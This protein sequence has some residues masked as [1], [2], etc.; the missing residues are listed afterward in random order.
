MRR[1][2]RS[3]ATVLVALALVAVGCGE[4][5][6]TAAPE[7]G[8]HGP[9]GQVALSR[10]ADT[11]DVDQSVQL[12]AIMPS[13]PGSVAPSVSWSSSDPN[14]AIV[15]QNGVLFA[16][17]SGR[18][19]VTAT[20]HGQS[21]ATTVTVRPSVREV[22]FDSDSLAIS[23]SQSVKLPYRVLDSDGNQ[24]DL[25]THTVEW[26]TSNAQVVPLTGDA[27]ITGRAIGAADLLLRVD[28]KEA[29]TRVKVLAKPVASVV[30]SPTSL[31]IGVTQNA[32]LTVSTYDVQENLLTGRSLTFSSSDQTIAY[33][34]SSGV[35]TGVANGQATITVTADGRKSTTVPVT[36]GAGPTNP[37]VSV[38]S[39]AV[40]LNAT[41]LTAGQTTQANAVT[42][43]GSG[44]VLTGRTIVWTTSDPTVASVDGAG[45]ISALKAGSVTVTATSEGKT[46]TGT[47][48]VTAPANAPTPVASMTLAVAPSIT[49]GQSAQATVVLKDAAGNVLSGRTVTWVSS[50]GSV[51]SVSSSGAVAALKAGGVTI[52]A[53]TDGV[54]AS[55]VVTAVAPNTA[56][57]MITLLAGATQ[58]NIGQ[59]TQITAVVRDANGAVLSGVPVTFTSSPS[60][61]VTISGSGV[62]AGVSVGSAQIYAKADTVVRSIGITVIDTTTTPPPPT[63]PLPPAG[64]GTLNAIATMA[65]LPQATVNATYPTPVRQIRVAAGANLQAALDAAQ[66]GDELLLAPGATWNGTFTLTDKGSSTAWITVRTD[67]PDATLG[68][69]GTRMTPSRASS[70]NLA[71]ILTT[72]N[73]AAIQTTLTAHHWRLTGLEIGGTAAAQE[74]N[75]I[76]RF[77]DGSGAQNSLS[78]VAHDLVLDRSFVH[79]MA[80]QA[81]RRCVSLQSASTAIVDS[82]ISDCHSNN[83]DSQAIVGWNG[84]GPYLIQNNHMEGGH[85]GL[86]FGGSDPSVPNLNPSDI[87]VIGN[88][89]TRPQAWKGVWQTKTI[90]ESKNARRMLIEGN[91]IEN[92]WPDAQVGYAVL[93]KSENQSGG[94]PWTQTTDV[95]VR[96]NLIRNVGSGFNI[97]SNPG[98]Y[99]AVPAARISI[100]DN[101]ITNLGLFG[102]DANP[103]QILGNVADMLVAHNS[104]SNTGSMAVSFDA[105]ANQRTVIHSNIVPNGSYGV[106]GSGTGIGTSTL[107]Q[108]APGSVFAYDIVVGADCKLYPSTTMCPST[109]PASPSTGYDG[110]A[111]GPDMSKVSAKTSAVV[112]GP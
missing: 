23:V 70:A 8:T 68:A 99:P 111:V 29:T 31:K 42:K 75:G 30:V 61:V 103:L 107:T 88:H 64:T 53:S 25:S 82:W 62:A 60:S 87:T 11:V 49:V 85:Q 67:V 13:A 105:A 109:A 19:I 12:S 72:T 50:D 96:Y 9:A 73:M 52:T 112:V 24:V 47:L 63:S 80:T 76:V 14:V 16:L 44:N 51:V 98:A 86:F 22:S 84:P 108:Y 18:T 46:G 59:L 55:A 36:V 20:S 69:P 21:D 27:T 71:K 93:L 77:G 74:I 26:I 41:T 101:Q 3:G 58:L 78:L 94:A 1:H 56:V 106:K 110:R 65:T 48:T 32:A 97:A 104:W 4:K 66:P 43:D 34:T 90:I 54:S 2:A 28:R 5:T 45:V 10:K 95:T 35:V 38:A 7:I 100:Y 57:H 102:A 83:G 91:V 40:T 89:I 92:V 37:A 17:K 39:I 81:V 33:V 79:G 6:P 15:T